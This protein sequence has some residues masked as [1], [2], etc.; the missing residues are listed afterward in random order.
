MSEDPRELGGPERVERTLG[1]MERNIGYVP[2]YRRA[3]ARGVAFRGTF[4]ATADAAALTTAEHMQGDPIGVVVRLS[5]G[6]GNPYTADKSSAKK[7]AVLGLAVR[8]ALPSGETAE[9]GSLSVTVFPARRPAD[10]EALTGAQKKGLPDGLPNPARLVA[11]LATHLPLIPGLKAVLGPK[12]ARSFATT[13][14]NGLTAYF[15]VD[16]GGTRRAFRYRWIPVAGEELLTAVEDKLLPAQYLISE[17]KLRVAQEPAAWDLVFQMAE[18][19]DPT[20]DLTKL[21]PESR[22]LVAAGRLVIDRVHEDQELVERSMFDPTKQAPGIEVSDD[23]IL[24]FRSEAYVE[25]LRRRLS[26]TKPAVKSE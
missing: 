12:P 18:P 19:G 16:A 15:L 1:N 5:N 10:F 21:W 11:F 25:S 26:E 9:W 8:F 2:G 24:H 23:P 6:A 7:G 4:T 20:H 14:F 17:M 3:H 22:P 13:R